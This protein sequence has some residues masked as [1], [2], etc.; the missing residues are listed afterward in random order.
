MFLIATI[1]VVLS[2]SSVHDVFYHLVICFAKVADSNT[3]PCRNT[4]AKHY[5]VSSVIHPYKRTKTLLLLI[6]TI[7]LVLY[8]CWLGFRNLVNLPPKYACSG[9]RMSSPFF[10]RD[11]CSLFYNQA[12]LFTVANSKTKAL[13]T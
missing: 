12:M 7:T 3:S 4:T 9:Q 10:T 13:Q 6:K 5:N 2:L 8:R 1:K 11:F